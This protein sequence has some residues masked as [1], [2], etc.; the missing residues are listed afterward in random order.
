MSLKL[1]SFI[2]LLRLPLLVRNFPI[3]PTTNIFSRALLVQMGGIVRY[4]W[5]AYCSRN[6]RCIAAFPFLQVLEASQQGTALQMGA[7]WYQLEVYCQ[8]FSDKLYGLGFH[9]ASSEV[10]YITLN[11]TDRITENMLRWLHRHC[12]A[13]AVL[14]RCPQNCAFADRGFGGEALPQSSVAAAMLVLPR[15][16]AWK[17]NL[18][19]GTGLEGS[20]QIFFGPPRPFHFPRKISKIICTGDFSSYEFSGGPSTGTRIS[21][22]CL[23]EFHRNWVGKT[24][25]HWTWWGRRRRPFLSSRTCPLWTHWDWTHSSGDDPS[26]TPLLKTLHTI[27]FKIITRMIFFGII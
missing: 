1:S 26:Y 11:V 4:K 6:W 19:T 5:E 25:V 3:F 22:P 14:S 9:L 2:V 10:C 24:D 16:F 23:K 8:Y 15:T 17:L 18:R 20:F 7:S 13:K 27:L 21:L 12:I